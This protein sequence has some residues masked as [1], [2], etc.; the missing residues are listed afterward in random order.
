MSRKTALLL[1]IGALLSIGGFL[2]WSAYFY[3]IGYPLDD[4]WIYQTYARNLT[5]S[6]EWAFVPGAPSGGSTGPL[7]VLFL[8]A[9]YLARVDH[10][11]WSYL[12]GSAALFGLGSAGVWG[13][14]RLHP[15]L[16][17]LALLAGAVLIFEWHLVWAAASGMETALAALLTAAV[18]AALFKAGMPPRAWLTIGLAIGIMVWI[19]P[20][21]ILLL[22]PAG[23]ALLLEAGKPLKA[24]LRDGALILTGFAIPFGLYLL[25]NQ[26]T[27]GSI[28]P[29]T[30]YAKQAEYAELQA[31]P[32]LT[33]YAQ[34]WLAPLTGVGVVL[35]P[36]FV[37]SLA[38]SIRQRAWGRLAAFLWLFGYLGTFALRLPV[39][40]QHG[41][42]A[43]PAMP[44]FFILGLGGTL[45]WVQSHRQSARMLPRALAKSGLLL[46]LLVTV[47]FW[48]LG[49][50]AFARDVAFIE[51]EM[52]AASRWIAANTEPDARIAAHDIGALGYFGEREII[53]LAGLI[54]PDVIPFI[55]DEA[56][57]A[58][59]LDSQRVDYLMT[60]PDW[61]PDLV[62]SLPLVYQTNSALTRQMGHENM[63][64]YRWR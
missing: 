12:L 43:M 19:R 3:G 46:I 20:D 9:G 49:S 36:G 35:L 41:R 57:L 64:V 40:Y 42:Y 39:T 58:A 37:L 32:L 53:D 25:F 44:I 31:I 23:F 17:N 29:N 4:A 33:R 6:G 59:Y 22:A 50:S 38:E 8:A 5:Q 30:F 7:W 55:R 18:L 60:F 54:S 45:R 27:A 62:E 51:T 48:G 10:F 1:T 21:G 16:G 24:K 34:Q 13:V 56:Q 61:Y 15:E 26:V 52:V 11:I 14:K 2:L 28:W 47:L 63:A